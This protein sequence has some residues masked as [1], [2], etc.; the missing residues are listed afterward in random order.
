MEDFVPESPPPLAV[1]RDKI[2]GCG[3]VVVL[4]G[5]RYGSRP[6]GETL[7][8]TELEYDYALRRGK[9]LHIFRVEESFPWPP[10][11]V[12]RGADAV[13]LARFVERVSAHTL[14]GF[15][16]LGAF[17]EDLMLALLPY[18]RGGSGPGGGREAG[19]VRWPVRVGSIPL[20]AECYQHRARETGLLED[21]LAGSGT[22]VL[23][24]VLSGLGGVG[25]T[26]LAAA[27]ARAA[28][29]DG[30]VEL[31]VWVSASSR[32]VIQASYAQAAREISATVS[33]EAEQDALWLV[34]WLQSTQRSWLVVLDDL[35]DPGDVRGLWPV[36]PG[37]RCLV[38]TR[39]RDAVLAGNGRQLIEVGLY[40]PREASEYLRQKLPAPDDEN[41]EGEL[42]GLAQDLGY[43]PL[44][45]AQAASFILDRQQTGETVAGYRRRFQ[46]RRRRLEQVFPRDALAD[47]YRFT[48][49]ATWAMSV[50]RADQLAPGGLAGGVLELVS[51]LDPN[52][53]PLEVL[54][55][56]AVLRFLAERQRVREAS[57]PVEELREVGELDCRDALM[58]L[59]R[60]NLVSV[61][62]SE[63]AR[64]I[65]TH[66]LVQRASLEHQP[67]QVL[68]SAVV[69]AADAL[70]HVW[71]EVE[72]D[73]ELGR[74]LRENA[75]RLTEH[76]PRLLW[77]RQGH[78]VLFRAGRSLGE[79]GLVNAAVAYWHD[80]TTTA[81]TVL[82]P[83]HPDHPKQPCPMAGGGGRSHRRGQRLGTPPHRPPAGAG[84]DHPDTLITRHNLARWRGE[85]GDPTGAASALEHL[86]TD[87]LR[88]L[89]PDHPDT[90]STRSNLAYWRGEA[91]DPTGAASALEHLL[92]DYLRVL[93][94]D[95]P[96]TLITR[97]NL[98]RWRGEAG[99]PTGA[100]SALEHLLT[101][102][103]RVLGPDHPDTLI[104]RHNLAYWRGEAGDPTG[105][106]SAL[107][108]L[109]TDYLRVLGP[110]HPDTLITRH[111][112]ARWRGEAGDP[113][114]AASALEHL[115]TDRLRVLGP[116][117]PDT[118]ITRHNLAYWRGEAGD[119]TG[120]A[121]ALEH[122]LTDRLRVLG[123]DHPDTLS[124]RSNLARWREQARHELPKT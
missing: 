7:G 15:G 8:Y 37:G 23:T 10:P 66:A 110:D 86:L 44:A 121:S 25:K 87:Y 120:A 29:R 108:H 99:D 104:T 80:M 38:T 78:S 111:N 84:P 93:G 92:T 51:V 74:A 54:T 113:T 58:N 57:G 119:P 60:L 91:G 81:S 55:A 102:Y 90:L 88:V 76:D 1:C 48:V 17:R 100:A 24:Q 79:C 14:R 4:V 109:L 67:Q 64:A 28:W 71:P 101:D 63:R 103:L 53:L 36:G 98:A 62:P 95:H 30:A 45:L 89:G 20:V 123:P 52:G 3:A 5:H 75:T 105:A 27:Y 85:A 35:S 21:A 42:V 46:D 77:D 43:L 112:L 49:A 33:G 107:E 97:H 69:A 2:E 124:T 72:R 11:E 31:L 47:D 22:T 12:E 116:D 41:T 70:V 106:A 118:L 16:D 82:G 34:A 6:P 19:G 73:T 68:A 117:H 13:A 39:R 96:S 115:L 9:S 122:L 94:P 50:E 83:D 26:Q 56:P 40:S 114:G 32:E 59:H 61:D 65:R 18:A